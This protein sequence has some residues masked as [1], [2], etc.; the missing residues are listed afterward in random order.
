[1]YDAA[2]D[3]K[4]AAALAN[5]SG[6]PILPSGLS[7]DCFAVS[8]WTVVLFAVARAVIRLITLS[9]SVQPGRIELK[10]MPSLP[11][12]IAR[13]LVNPTVAARTLFDN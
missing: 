11:S 4:K 9:V 3:S 7:V 13:V 6:C 2:G 10:R 12:S 8:S 5:S 1:M